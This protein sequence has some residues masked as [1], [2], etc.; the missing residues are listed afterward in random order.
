MALAP[1]TVPAVQARLCLR[2][3]FTALRSI[4]ETLGMEVD[5]DP[6]PDGVLQLSYDDYLAGVARI[7]STTFR[8]DR[9]PEQAWPDF[10]GWRVNYEAVAYALMDRLDA[11]PA[12][13]T[14][15]RANGYGPVDV[16]RPTNRIPTP[17]ESGAAIVEKGDPYS[18]VSTTDGAGTRSDRPPS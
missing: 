4:A 14:G 18:E 10:R 7:E 9:T 12:P 16:V 17:H 11:V 1:S 15:P 13:W 5:H 3:G 2:M 6:D 8:M